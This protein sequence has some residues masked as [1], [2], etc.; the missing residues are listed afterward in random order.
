MGAN[1]FVIFC[2]RRTHADMS[3]LS[4]DEKKRFALPSR[5]SLRTESLSVASEVSTAALGDLHRLR[6]F[7]DV[8]HGVTMFFQLYSANLGLEI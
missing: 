4:A 5:P 2:F 3:K 8:S 6:G 1:K 7:V